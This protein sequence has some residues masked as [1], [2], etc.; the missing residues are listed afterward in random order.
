M[1]LNL[2]QVI[3]CTLSFYLPLS[4]KRIK[5]ATTNSCLM[6]ANNLNLFQIREMARNWIRFCKVIR[7]ETCI[8]FK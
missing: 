8:E 7:D 5:R 1:N 2:F 6:V 3:S 4:V